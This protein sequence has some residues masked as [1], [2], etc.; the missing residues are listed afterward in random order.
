MTH[1]SP[2]LATLFGESRT[3]GTSWSRLDAIPSMDVYRRDN[4]VVVHLDLP[5]IDRE[6][7]QVE[8][9]GDWVTVS[10]ERPYAPEPGDLVFASE[11]RF[12]RFERRFR[13]P[14]IDSVS[15]RAE[16][17]NGVLTLTLQTATSDKA[18]RI[19]VVEHTTPIT[20]VPAT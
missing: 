2:L 10:G 1:I 11:R 15:A 3:L 8:V 18:A 12:G 16:L 20:E 5:G 4:A 17:R 7:I 13:L 19:E 9:S 6:A 14:G